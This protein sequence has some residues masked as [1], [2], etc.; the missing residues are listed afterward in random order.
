MQVPFAPVCATLGLMSSATHPFR[1]R[2]A[3]DAPGAVGA[4][5]WNESL[6]GQESSET[7][8]RALLIGGAVALTAGGA[9]LSIA[10]LA[11]SATPSAPPVHNEDRPALAVQK[12]YGWNFGA[13]G[14]PLKFGAGNLQPVAPD[15]LDSL[16]RRLQPSS[17]ALLPFHVAT[18]L[19]AASSTNALAYDLRTNLRT[20]R[21]S[22]MQTAFEAGRALSKKLKSSLATTAV[23]VELPGPEAVAFAAGLSD[24][25]DS[26]FLFGNW[27][28]PR[29][30]VPSHLTL[31]AAAEYLP[32][33]ESS[34]SAARSKRPVFVLD[35]A[36][37]NLPTNLEEQFDNRYIAQLPSLEAMKGLGVTQVLC[38]IASSRQMPLNADLSSTLT[39]WSQGGI[40]FSMMSVSAWTYDV[41]DQVARLARQGTQGQDAGA[42]DGGKAVASERNALPLFGTKARDNQFEQLY[43]TLFAP[44]PKAKKMPPLEPVSAWA[45]PE[46]SLAG[47]HSFP[48]AAVSVVRPMSGVLPVVVGATG[49]V[50]GARLLRGGTYDR[51]GYSSWGGG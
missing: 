40:Q 42:P 50:L 24:V 6:A 43:P 10:A 20:A 34:A 47:M 7:S 35:S 31:A 2:Q 38:V 28:H 36:R 8:R 37:Q 49:I 32:E 46:V 19:S 51:T 48:Q 29:G 15:V 4:T 21:T 39:E 3:V 14:E 22:A 45:E 25:F 23:V 26:V 18:L 12:Q 27:P 17:A 41:A 1:C 11:S 33:F 44:P 5:W 9:M 13:T 30:V 16:E